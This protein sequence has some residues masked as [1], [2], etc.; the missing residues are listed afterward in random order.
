MDRG[1]LSSLATGDPSFTKRWTVHVCQFAQPGLTLTS[2]GNP[3]SEQKWPSVV[4]QGCGRHA[5]LSPQSP[6]D[7]RAP[8]RETQRPS[9]DLAGNHVSS[10]ESLLFG[11]SFFSL[12]SFH[13]PPSPPSPFPQLLKERAFCEKAISPLG[14]SRL[15]KLRRPPCHSLP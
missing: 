9:T 10:L 14:N 15:G 2:A 8:R 6:G 7:C 11:L 5:S 3:L 1:V 13:P 12:F 4:T